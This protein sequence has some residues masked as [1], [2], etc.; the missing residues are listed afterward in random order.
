[1][2]P[3]TLSPLRS[4]RNSR[5]AAGPAKT[6]R[7]ATRGETGT[8]PPRT[9]GGILRSAAPDAL[10]TPPSVQLSEGKT[11]PRESGLL[12][13]VQDAES[14]CCSLRRFLCKAHSAA[15]GP[16]PSH[17]FAGNHPAVTIAWSAQ[18]APHPSSYRDSK[19][20]AVRHRW[21]RLAFLVAGQTVQC[22]QC[23]W[24]VGDTDR[25]NRKRP[26]ENSSAECVKVVWTMGPVGM[27]KFAPAQIA[28]EDGR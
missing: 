3:R 18:G 13:P 26:A 28:R 7:L 14:R 19:P 12:A 15:A 6:R 5:S 2:Q 9:S 22:A 23:L 27:R 21:P 16:G 17:P 11:A 20:L 4:N 25:I 10:I 8:P 24:A 1:M